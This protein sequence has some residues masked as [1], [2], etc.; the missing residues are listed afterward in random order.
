MPSSSHS[1]TAA[2]LKEALDLI[3][4]DDD[5]NNINDNIFQS[6]N[7]TDKDWNDKQLVQSEEK[8]TEQEKDYPKILE[9][10]HPMIA[11]AG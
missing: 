9:N 10:D 4:I 5:T 7:K 1:S 8:V 11:R 6:R 2:I 3:H